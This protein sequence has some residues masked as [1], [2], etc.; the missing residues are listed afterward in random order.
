MV[1]AELGLDIFDHLIDEC[2]VSPPEF[3][4]PLFSLSGAIDVYGTD[5]V[6]VGER[7]NPHEGAGSLAGR[8]LR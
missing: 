5:G 1:D 3:A 4:R 2:A 7:R 6:S 8:G